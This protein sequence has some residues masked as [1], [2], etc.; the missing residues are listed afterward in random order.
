MA[1]LIAVPVIAGAWESLEDQA[2]GPFALSG[3][4]TITDPAQV[5]LKLLFSGDRADSPSTYYLLSISDNEVRLAKVAGNKST[6]L[7]TAGTLPSP[8][9][10]QDVE[11]ALHRDAWRI[12]FIWNGEVLTQAF[13]TELSG[14][15]VAYEAVSGITIDDVFLQGVGDIETNDTF[16]RTEKEDEEQMKWEQLSGSWKLIS[17]REDR[18]AGQMQADKTANAFSYY[19]T[20]DGVGLAT[21]G[22]WF[23]RNCDYSLAARARNQEGAFGLAFYVQDENNYLLLRWD[24]RFTSAPGGARLRLLAFVDGKQRV[25]AERPGGYFPDQWYQL[26][27]KICDGHVSCYI[28]GE[29]VLETSTLLFGQG[30]VGLYV[31]GKHGTWFDD[32]HVASWDNMVENFGREVV[33][34]WRPVA[35][36][37]QIS[38]GKARPTSADASLLTTGSPAWHDY[39]FSSRIEGTAGAYGIA[40][41]CSPA[42]E[43]YLFRWSPAGAK[44]SY[45]GK[46][47]L[48]RRGVD[49]E[50]ILAEKALRV[51][52]PSSVTATAI[53]ETDYIA[54]LLNGERVVDAVVSDGTAGGVGLYTEAA[55]SVAFD[56]ARV[57]P[58]PAR[59]MARVTKEFTDEK[60]HFEMV[61]WASS[62]HNWIKPDD[63]D[64]PKIWWTKGDYHGPVQ[65]RF[66]LTQLGNV[67]GTMKVGLETDESRPD[68]GYRLEITASKGSRNLLLKLLRSGKEV[69]TARVTAQAR[70]CPVCVERRGDYIIVSVDD[71]AVITVMNGRN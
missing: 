49:G 55:E 16:E 45:A 58:L 61:E 30:Q 3:E 54:G 25:L 33:G 52:T 27:A 36:E 22:F 57:E 35:G 9:N 12:A 48:V 40:V 26:R 8:T 32:V 38:S 59:T 15:A 47:Q 62:R 10:G 53:V 18:Q 56:S 6:P 20:A 50:S 65:V 23:W 37:W 68:T 5:H 69:Q 7:G 1:V 41:G 51:G 29:L 19:G 42:G 14:P 60:T 39:S 4:A 63:D 66:N 24:N 13:D 44:T 21:T 46:A 67:A 31:E 17:L 64:S 43:G 70:I 11:F 2:D 34:K 71:K 28:D